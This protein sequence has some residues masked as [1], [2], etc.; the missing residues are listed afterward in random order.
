VFAGALEWPGWC[1]SAR[2]EEDALQ[3]LLDYAPR[4]AAV[5]KGTRLGF[6]PPSK[7]NLVER[8]DGDAA[9]DFG[10]PGTPTRYD[11][12]DVSD[13]ELKR[14]HG[15]LR[16]CWRTFDAALESAR[17]KALAKGPRGGGRAAPKILEHVL[18]A[19]GGYLHMVAAKVPDGPPEELADRTRKAVLAGLAAAAHGEVPEEGPRGGKRWPARYFARR[20]AWHVLDHAWEIEDRLD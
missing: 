15:V 8:I 5:L 3:A 11:A 10:V 14:L 1:R 19:E 12:G 2:T 4:Y 17:G 20:V 18:G 9:T 6:K 16:A 13:A 7:L